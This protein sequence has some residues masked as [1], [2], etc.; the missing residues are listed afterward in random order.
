M[1][2]NESNYFYW[3]NWCLVAAFGALVLAITSR[4]VT[5][6][7]ETFAL[8]GLGGMVISGMLTIVSW[9]FDK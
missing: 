7:I 1:I 5:V 2:K 3:A 6:K 9:R 8:M 4:N